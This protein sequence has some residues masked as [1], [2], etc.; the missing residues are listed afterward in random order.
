[1]PRVP[2]PPVSD[3]AAPAHGRS[4]GTAHGAGTP[5]EVDELYSFGDPGR[6]ASA[7]PYFAAAAYGPMQLRRFLRAQLAPGERVVGF[8]VA[9]IEP[10]AH[11]AAVSMAL[12]ALPVFG[13]VLASIDTIMT[14]LRRTVVVLT[15]RRLLLLRPELVG[16]R[17]DGAGIVLDRSLGDIEVFGRGHGKGRS[18]WARFVLSDGR[19][20]LSPQTLRIS[21]ARS[22]AAGR[23]CEALWVLAATAER[24]EDTGIGGLA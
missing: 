22:P 19:R 6:G 21:Y 14:T 12:T 2:I 24:A 7:H 15:D 8:G 4:N 9:R 11:R 20:R 18:R 5:S 17:P 16:T 1:M 10:G 23:L 13:Q 3:R